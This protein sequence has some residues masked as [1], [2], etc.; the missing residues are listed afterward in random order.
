MFPSFRVLPIVV[1]I[2]TYLRAESID[3]ATVV[4]GIPNSGAGNIPKRSRRV[5]GIADLGA[6][7][8]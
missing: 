8:A 1:G 3:C 2:V 6:E 4:G 7:A 5:C